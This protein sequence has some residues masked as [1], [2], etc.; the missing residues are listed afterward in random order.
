EVMIE[1]QIEHEINDF[2]YRLRLQGLDIEQYL[3]LTNTKL[4]DLK[5][6]LRPA[7][8]K[9][10]KTDL[11]LEAIGKKENIKASEEDI[12]KELEKIAK[13]YKQVDVDKFKE[14]MKKG[15]LSF[16]EAGIIRDKIIDLLV[17]NAKII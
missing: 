14:N 6:Q 17:S 15:D 7:A 9:K 10:I 4:E 13:E 1:N 16:L 11:V 5:E 8:E 2:N 3:N 12:D